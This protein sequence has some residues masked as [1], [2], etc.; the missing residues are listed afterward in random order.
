MSIVPSGGNAL[1]LVQQ[2]DARPVIS[3]E[4]RERR[5]EEANKLEEKLNFIQDNVATRIFNVSGSS[6][7]AGSGDFH[8]YRMARRREQSRLARIDKAAEEQQ[9]KDEFERQREKRVAECE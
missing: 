6:A 9:E 4:E 7:G 8:Q 5:V 1:A 2:Q 3:E